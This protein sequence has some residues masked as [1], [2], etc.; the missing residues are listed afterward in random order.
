MGFRS[1]AAMLSG[2]RASYLDILLRGDVGRELSSVEG[3]VWIWDI[4][5]THRVMGGWVRLAFTSPSESILFIL[6]QNMLLELSSIM[7]K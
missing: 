5:G 2:N 7:K 1:Y 6:F 4:C 3:F